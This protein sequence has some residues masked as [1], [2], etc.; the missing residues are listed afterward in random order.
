MLHTRL[1]ARILAFTLLA[2]AAVAQ[3]KI[4][5]TVQRGTATKTAV[6]DAAPATDAMKALDFLVAASCTAPGACEYL[7]ETDAIRKQLVA[8]FLQQLTVTPGTAIKAANDSVITA[9]KALDKAKADYVTAAQTI[10]VN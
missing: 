6:I 8:W 7:N 2:T 1:L 5:I 10:P 4:T 3:D 9:Q